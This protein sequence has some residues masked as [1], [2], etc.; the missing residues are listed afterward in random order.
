[1]LERAHGK[2]LADGDR[3][4]RDHHHSDARQRYARAEQPAVVAAGDGVQA[5][6]LAAVG[7]HAGVHQRTSNVARPISTSTTEMIQKRTITRGTG[8]PLSSTWGLLGAIQ[9]THRPVSLNEEPGNIPRH[10]PT[11][12]PPPPT[13][14]H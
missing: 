5:G 7:M 10:A 3:A 6:R 8:Q 9:N 4:R 2:A 14:P 12:P 11:P 13:P 1:M